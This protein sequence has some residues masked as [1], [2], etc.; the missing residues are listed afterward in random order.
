MNKGRMTS[1]ASVSGRRDSWWRR[2]MPRH[3]KPGED[4]SRGRERSLVPSGMTDDEV[5]GWHH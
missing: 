3:L 5:V 4:D 2:S 1:R